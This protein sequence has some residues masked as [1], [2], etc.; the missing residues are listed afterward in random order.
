MHV[1]PRV[2][3]L[4]QKNTCH[5]LSCPARCPCLAGSS[6]RSREVELGFKNTALLGEARPAGQAAAGGSASA[7]QAP[8]LPSAVPRGG[9]DDDVEA[10]VAGEAEDAA[11]GPGHSLAGGR[12]RD[13]V[14]SPHHATD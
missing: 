4:T 9:A 10:E 12:G 2:P 3:V 14:A 6:S 5:R 1:L 13:A 11:R 7:Q 8:S